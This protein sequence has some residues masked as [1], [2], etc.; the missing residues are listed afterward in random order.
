[1]VTKQRAPIQKKPSIRNL[2]GPLPRMSR[3]K[4]IVDKKDVL[5]SASVRARTSIVGTTIYHPDVKPSA[6][7]RKVLAALER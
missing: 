7:G 2:E 4:K 6:L 5:K 3:A 1:M